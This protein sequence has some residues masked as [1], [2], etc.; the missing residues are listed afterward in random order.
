[1][2]CIALE[3]AND[4]APNQEQYH[5]HQLQNNKAMDDLFDGLHYL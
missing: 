3:D 5:M 4:D 2:I 1:V